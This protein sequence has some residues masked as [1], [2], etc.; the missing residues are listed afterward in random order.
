M[1]ILLVRHSQAVGQQP[2]APLT[3]LG[4]ERAYSLADFIFEYFLVDHIIS[5]P[6]K[7]AMDTIGPLAKRCEITVQTDERLVERDFCGSAQWDPAVCDAFLRKSFEDFDFRYADGETNQEALARATAF[8]KDIQSLSATNVVIVSHG[9]LCT[10]LLGLFMEQG[11]KSMLQ[12]SNPDL[13][14]L[15]LELKSKPVRLWTD[16]GPIKP[17]TRKSARAILLDVT[18]LRVFLFL[19]DDPTVGAR[20]QGQPLWITP[21]GGVTD[22]EDLQK[23]LVRELWEETGLERQQ[24]TIHGHLWTSGKNLMWNNQ[25][26]YFL[27]HFYIVQLKSRDDETFSFAHQTPEERSVLKEH[28][29]WNWSSLEMSDAMVVPL[30]LRQFRDLDWK[31]N[32]KHETLSGTPF[33]TT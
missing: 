21:G 5:S 3:S 6:Y 31:N 8:L 9:N 14:I 23:A 20:Q 16:L 15:D 30:Q 22:D 32:L 17:K 4:D 7:R 29:W 2:E 13:F 24:Y 25:P 12:L 27:D 33:L 1:T 28:C 26:A 18:A 11:Y 19:L 10:L